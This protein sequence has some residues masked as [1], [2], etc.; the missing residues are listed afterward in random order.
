M[1]RGAFADELERRR[2]LKE[3]W[4]EECLEVERIAGH[5]AA[6]LYPL[7]NVENGVRTPLGPGTL[8]Q[9]F[10]DH[11]LSPGAMVM[12]LRPRARI[13]EKKNGKWVERPGADFVSIE[14]VLP[15]SSSS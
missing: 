1:T 14:D 7:L 11:H 12:H 6:R 2:L 15:Y 8:L 5:R 13:K 10:E 4:S 3:G 9:A